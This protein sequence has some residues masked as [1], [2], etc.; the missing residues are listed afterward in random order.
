V[1]RLLTIELNSVKDMDD[2]AVQGHGDFTSFPRN[3]AY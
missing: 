2:L 3:G 1:T